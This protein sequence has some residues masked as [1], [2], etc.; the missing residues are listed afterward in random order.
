MHKKKG[1]A[2]VKLSDLLHKISLSSL[3]PLLKKD[4]ENEEKKESKYYFFHENT[5]RNLA[6]HRLKEGE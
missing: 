4:A 5:N 1:N 6:E 2:D 3:D